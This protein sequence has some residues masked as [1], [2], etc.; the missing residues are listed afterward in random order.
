MLS[1]FNGLRRLPIILMVLSVSFTLTVAAQMPISS[2]PTDAEVYFIEPKDGQIFE[3]TGGEGVEIRFGLTGMDVSPAGIAV[4]NSGHHHLLINLD[5][6]PNLSMPLPATD[7]IR[8]FGKGQT[9]TWI[10]LSPGKHKLQLLL[11]NY[12]HIP[13]NP[14]VMSKVIEIEIK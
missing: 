9:S 1:E 10:K 5:Q 8:H 12:A 3:S 6:I 4:P 7:Q 2:A 11:G 13:H 14:A